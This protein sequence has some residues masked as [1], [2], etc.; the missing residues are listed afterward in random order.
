MKELKLKMK[1]ILFTLFILF[2][3]CS[4][5][6]VFAQSTNLFLINDQLTI[7]GED[8]LATGIIDTLSERVSLSELFGRFTLGFQFSI[9]TGADTLEVFIGTTA[10]F[11]AGQ[12]AII[13]P[14][15]PFN[16]AY[17]KIRD[18]LNVFV[19]NAGVNKATYLYWLG[20]I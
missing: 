13:Y 18:N 17:N 8:T 3:A 12:T 9:Y 5:D 19:R 7:A 11:T 14:G 16:T 1:K 6:P 20:G 2:C 15:I 4:Q 10:A